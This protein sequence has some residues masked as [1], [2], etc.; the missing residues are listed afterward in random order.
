VV[1]LGSSDYDGG[2]RIYDIAAGTLERL[3]PDSNNVRGEW[4]RDGSRV[5][6]AEHVDAESSR[7]VSRS[8]DGSGEPR[9]LARG[10]RLAFNQ[11]SIGPATG[12]SAWR[13]G[14]QV[15]GDIWLAPTES[16]SAARAFIAT[17]AREIMPRVSPNGRLLAYMS[18]ETGSYE[19]YVREIPGPGARVPV[20]VAGGTEPMWAPD[21]SAL[22]YR[23]PA[24]MMSAT[25]VERPLSV[26]R[27]D[28]L[29]ADIYRR[30]VS[31]GEYSV[32]PNG[33][34]FLMLRG[35]TFESKIWVIVNWPQLLAKPG[36]TAAE[37]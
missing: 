3:T 27:R 2:L 12:L 33:R 36:G 13:R 23:G 8:W 22:Y 11:L 15:Q 34:E 16:L 32:F 10:G 18:D 6:Y 20:S 14:A 26:S 7:V 30:S 24:R 25:I 9:V 28:S 1:R 19:V 29:F 5:V 21:G 35:T 17:P 4:T 37:K 31:F